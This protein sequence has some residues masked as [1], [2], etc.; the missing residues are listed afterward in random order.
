MK[1]ITPKKNI[2]ISKMS[3]LKND[4]IK[5]SRKSR[6]WDGNCEIQNYLI[7]GAKSFAKEK[8]YSKCDAKRAWCFFEYLSQYDSDTS[9]SKKVLED[10]IISTN[11]G[12]YYTA[13]EFL[14]WLTFSIA[15]DAK[16]VW[17]KVGDTSIKNT[18]QHEKVLLELEEIKTEMKKERDEKRKKKKE[19]VAL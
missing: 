4:V 11:G 18:P 13:S 8:A 16:E 6:N 9:G 12:N 2:D 7:N 1:N 17:H 10:M 19:G 14:N 5:N 3:K 15:S